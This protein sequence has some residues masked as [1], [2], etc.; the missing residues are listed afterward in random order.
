M[1]N[2]LYSMGMDWWWGWY[3]QYDTHE[4][5]IRQNDLLSHCTHTC[6]QHGRQA[7]P[8]DVL[9]PRKCSELAG[10]AVKCRYCRP[11]AYHGVR[12][13]RVASE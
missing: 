9:H 1:L 2:A 7:A 3:I 4:H 11:S 5:V 12:D 6:P 13:V 8:L 10:D